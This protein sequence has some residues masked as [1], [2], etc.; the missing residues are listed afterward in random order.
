MRRIRR[1]NSGP[2]PRTGIKGLELHRR[3]A[4]WKAGGCSVEAF[5]GAIRYLTRYS[6]DPLRLADWHFD[7][8][9][10]RPEARPEADGQAVA[11]EL[12]DFF[13]RPAF[14]APWILERFRFFAAPSCDLF[15][16]PAASARGVLLLH[17]RGWQVREICREARRSKNHVFLLRSSQPLAELQNMCDNNVLVLEDEDRV[18]VKV[19]SVRNA[20]ARAGELKGAFRMHWPLWRRLALKLCNVGDMYREPGP[21]R[22]KESLRQAMGA[23]CCSEAKPGQKEQLASGAAPIDA[24][25]KSAQPG[26][27]PVA[28]ANDGD[29]YNYKV[30]PDGS[31]YEGQ[32]KD[33]LKHGKGRFIYPDG[34]VYDG[35]WSDG[36]AHGH[37]TYTSKQSKYVGEWQS[38]L[39]HGQAVEEW[40]DTSKYTG[41]YSHGQKHGKGRFEWPDGSVYD[42]EFRNN[43]VEGEGT[44]TW[45]DGRQYKGQWV[46]NRMH[47]EGRYEWPDGRAYEGQY[48][49][50]LK[51]G[52]GTFLWADGRKFTGQWKDGKQHGV[53]VF[54]TAHGDQRTGEW[55]EGVRVC[56]VDEAPNNVQ[57]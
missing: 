10:T 29:G 6:E 18:K 42:G 30:F 12:Q 13:F 26:P 51:E 56:W 43:N 25:A 15:A 52:E 33:G 54:R 44:F 14:Q 20:G 3:G 19:C 16:R 46:D 28:A 35:E 48:I 27:A 2:M 40:D 11:A 38:D 24:K 57:A 34:D 5:E 49:N 9:A 4:P 8:V 23:A 1:N 36:K 47:G 55:R 7:V 41:T 50:D 37:G 21:S 32:W 45:K 17:S 22:A 53:G 39:K 31:R